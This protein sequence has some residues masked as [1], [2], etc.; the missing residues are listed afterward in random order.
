MRAAVQ[1]VEHDRHRASRGLL[2]GGPP[3]F[4]HAHHVQ[5]VEV[6]RDDAEEAQALEQRDGG[7]LGECEDATLEGEE[8]QLGVEQII[9]RHATNCAGNRDQATERR[10][11]WLD[12]F[13]IG[14][15]ASFPVSLRDV[16]PP[17]SPPASRGPRRSCG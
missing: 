8:A 17:L 2:D 6:A 14:A 13:A 9:G 11:G 4:R 5:L 7:I 3:Q 16:P 1:R 12:G 15:P 10:L